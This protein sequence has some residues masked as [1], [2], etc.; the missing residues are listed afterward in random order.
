V[1]TTPRSD[2]A[3]GSRLGKRSGE[4]RRA[5]RAALDR[6]VAASRQ[7]QGFGPNVSDLEVLAYVAAIFE[8]A[9]DA[10]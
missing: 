10:S 8:G 1:A 6:I 4:A 5:R 2:T 9:S 3:A 7:A